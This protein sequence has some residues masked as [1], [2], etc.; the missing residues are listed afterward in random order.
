MLTPVLLC[1]LCR[2]L[3]IALGEAFVFLTF[4]L[5]LT[6]TVGLGVTTGGLTEGI[7]ALSVVTGAGITGA[8]KPG[9]PVESCGGTTAMFGLSVGLGIVLG[10][11]PACGALPPSKRTPPTAV[12]PARILM[13]AVAAVAVVATAVLLAA[14]LELLAVNAAFTAV[15]T[16]TTPL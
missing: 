6:I 3:T 15:T 11:T 13:A 14:T 12:R 16:A 10:T 7:T 5:L 4:T 8:P 2:E 1:K 9:I